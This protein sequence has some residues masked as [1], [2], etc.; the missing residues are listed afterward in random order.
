ML[1]LTLFYSQFQDSR[2]SENGIKIF[3]LPCDIDVESVPIDL[4]MKF[5]ELQNYLDLKENVLPK[6]FLEF[7]RGLPRKR[8][9]KI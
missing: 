2:S 6:T 5:V 8:Y 7:Y 9:P 3:P 1:Q 4:Q